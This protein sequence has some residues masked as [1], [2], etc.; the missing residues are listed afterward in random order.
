VSATP[1]ATCRALRKRKRAA[2]AMAARFSRPCPGPLTRARRTIPVDS[3]FALPQLDQIFLRLA[4][5]GHITADS[6]ELF[7]P[8]REHE[9][10]FTELFAHLGFRLIADSRG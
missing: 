6:N 5:G 9:R 7:Q 1:S 3:P 8:L 10:K 4:R 2:I